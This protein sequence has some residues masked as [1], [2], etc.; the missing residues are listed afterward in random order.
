VSRLLN[1]ITSR[2]FNNSPNM[3]PAGDS[4]NGSPPR[5]FG[6]ASPRAYG[7]GGATREE[8]TDLFGQLEMKLMARLDAVLAA[9]QHGDGIG[10]GRESGS[11]GSSGGR[12][13]K[14]VPAGELRP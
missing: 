3:S 1:T 5:T 2:K 10:P 11:S 12:E 7:G 13:M 6:G 9:T 4:G 8:V 14:L